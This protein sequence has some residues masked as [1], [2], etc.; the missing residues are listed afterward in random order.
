M[1]ATPEITTPSMT[2]ELARMA[3]AMMGMHL[4]ARLLDKGVS[5]EEAATAAIRALPTLRDAVIGMIGYDTVVAVDL[6]NERGGRVQLYPTMEA[7]AAD[8]ELARHRHVAVELGSVVAD[9]LATA[10]GKVFDARTIN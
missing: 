6:G 4:Q 8:R 1:T 10:R 9:V 3:A 2:P 5:F 7:A